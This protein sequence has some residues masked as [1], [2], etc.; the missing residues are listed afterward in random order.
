LKATILL[1]LLTE[2]FE[3][4]SG[5]SVS[6]ASTIFVSPNDYLIGAKADGRLDYIKKDSTRIINLIAVAPNLEQISLT[7]LTLVKLEQ[8]Y[9]SVLVKQPSGIYKYESKRKDVVLSETPFTIDKTST[10][11]IISDEQ[12]GNYLLQIKN[13][14]G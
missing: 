3:P 9:L 14:S 2:V 10:N 5:R 4:D 7:D 1:K 11:Y 6:A 12:P 8:K 13:K